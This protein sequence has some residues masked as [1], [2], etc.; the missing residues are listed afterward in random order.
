MNAQQLYLADGRAANVWFCGTC[1][2]VYK[3]K[4]RDLAED[5]CKCRVCGESCPRDAPD[6]W[7]NLHKS[8]HEDERRRRH[9]ERFDKA[10]EVADYD[11]WVCVEPW[12]PQDGYFASAEEAE[13]YIWDVHEDGDE[14]PEWAFCCERV[15]PRWPDVSDIVER[16]ADD[17]YEGYEDHLNGTKE[18]E[19]ALKAFAEANADLCSWTVDYTR[20]VRLNVK[21]D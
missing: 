10:E 8:C 9:A 6:T 7:T 4:V 12:G 21:G 19:A 17:M 16:F 5:C 15:E 3:H 20:K 14:L 2:T 1:R 11:G 13:E 18:L